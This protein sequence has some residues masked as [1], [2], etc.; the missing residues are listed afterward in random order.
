MEEVLNYFTSEKKPEAYFDFDGFRVEY[1]DWWFNIRP[2]NTEPYL[3]LIV[4]AGSAELLK[5]KTEQIKTIL[6]KYM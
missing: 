1:P 3:R 4:E 6:A 5:E 2:S